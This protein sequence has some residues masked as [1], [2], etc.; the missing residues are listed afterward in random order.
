MASR[1]QVPTLSLSN[2]PPTQLSLI[3][4]HQLFHN[5]TRTSLAL[6]LQRAEVRIINT[7]DITS[8]SWRKGKTYV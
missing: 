7:A 2:C 8:G 6:G 3:N 1:K 5:S 4:H